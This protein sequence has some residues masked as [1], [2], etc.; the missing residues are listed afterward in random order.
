[1]NPIFD[2]KVEPIGVAKA[3]IRICIDECYGFTDP[4]YYHGRDHARILRYCQANTNIDM[5]AHGE[6]VDALA[7][8]IEMLRWNAKVTAAK[9]E[10]RAKRLGLQP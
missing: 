9:L 1:M 4:I 8:E 3:L 2:P 10:K 7:K 5:E 6:H